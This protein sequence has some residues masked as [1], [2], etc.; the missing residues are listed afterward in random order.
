MGRIVYYTPGDPND[1]SAVEAPAI[2]SRVNSDGTLDLSVFP[3]GAAPYP[4]SNVQESESGGSEL[5]KWCWPTAAPT[6]SQPEGSGSEGN[7]GKAP[8]PTEGEGSSTGDGSG[9]A[10]AD[11]GDQ[12]EGGA[13]SGVDSLGS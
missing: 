7:D 2:V 5:A 6:G 4:A 1:V 11:T 10:P 13:R 8:A 9:E 12:G 3:P